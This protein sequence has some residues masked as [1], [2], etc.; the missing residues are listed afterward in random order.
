[1][2]FILVK[3]LLKQTLNINIAQKSL[4]ATCFKQKGAVRRI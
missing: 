2:L 1:M 3:N 4:F